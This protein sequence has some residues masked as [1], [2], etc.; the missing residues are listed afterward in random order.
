MIRVEE[1]QGP[2]SRVYFVWF[3][4]PD[5]NDGLLAEYP[6]RFQAVK[7]ARDYAARYGIQLHSAEV[8]PFRREVA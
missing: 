8:L 7:F 5:G 3:V 1:L 6:T 4:A 2:R